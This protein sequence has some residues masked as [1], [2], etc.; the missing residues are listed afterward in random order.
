M[1]DVQIILAALWVSLML[2]Y[3]LG[4]SLRIFS[5]DF[6]PGEIAGQKATQSMWMMA[7]VVMLIPIVMVFLTLVVPMPIIGWLNIILS[8]FLFL[9][10]L[11]GVRSYPGLYDRFLIVVS[12]L[13]NMVIVW[14]AWNWIFVAPL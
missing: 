14:Y 9:F 2:T 12:L 13:F 5:G 11:A 8:I 4:D 1:E 3:L 6:V 7:A 10:N